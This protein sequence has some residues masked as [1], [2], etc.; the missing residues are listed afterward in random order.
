[1]KKILFAIISI[2]LLLALCS[3]NDT[4]PKETTDRVQHSTPAET[5]TE[6]P[7]ETPA[8]VHAHTSKVEKEPTCTE[9]GVKV[10]TCECGDTFTEAIEATGH[11]Q[12]SE[13]TVIKE[14]SY[15]EEG[16]EGT[17]CII[18]GE[19]NE[20][21]AIKTKPLKVLFIGNSFAVDTSHLAP[22]IAKALGVK[23]MRF[24]TLYIGGCSINKHYN[25]FIGEK[26]DY[27]YYLN[28][29]GSWT[30]VKNYSI[31]RALQE[32]EWDYICIQHGTG[33]GSRYTKA[34]SYSKLDDLVKLIKENA[35]EN[36][37]IAFNMAWVMEPDSTHAEMVSYG[38]N[39]LRMYEKLTETT[40]NYV[41]TVEGLDIVVPTGTTIQNARTV[42]KK[43][44]T[45]DKFHLTK[46][47]G[48]YIASMTLLEAMCGIE[49]D[50]LKWLTTG[51]TDSDLA[52]AKEAVNAAI[53]NPYGITDL[54]K[55]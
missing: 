23:E 16:E 28:V 38:G 33:D 14:A 4:P 11:H 42:I 13:W 31:Q 41:A 17:Y 21:K 7:S 50:E 46:D 36:A 20:S 45:R 29:G 49:T 53:E 5:P 26:K 34:A 30:T 39:Q 47:L 32:T 27:T 22:N 6:T 55:Q 18:C 48:R 12:W 43:V 25:N 10:Y 37:V 1:M 8:H 51:V 52:S 9:N 40:K 35:N 3:C 19:I 2:L 54:G 15:T 24:G 44:L